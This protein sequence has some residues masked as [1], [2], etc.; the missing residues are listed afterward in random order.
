MTFIRKRSTRKRVS[1][2]LASLALAI[3]AL[4]IPSVNAEEH[5]VRTQR[6]AWLPAVLFIEPGDSVIWKGMRSHETELITGMGPE[7]AFAWDSEVDAEDFT[8][9]FEVEGAYIYSCEVHMNF[10][11]V[12]AIIVGEVQPA[13]LTSIDAALPNVEVGQQAVRRIIGQVKRMLARRN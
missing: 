4:T 9:T 3:G 2:A 7:G 10:G 11:M 8:V 6:A 12:G 5:I 1:P 13:N